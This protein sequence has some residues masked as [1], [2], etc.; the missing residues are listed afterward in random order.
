MPSA[1]HDS[2][3]NT[4]KGNGADGSP[5]PSHL[6]RARSPIGQAGF[7]ADDWARQAQQH[8]GRD[9]HQQQRN[10]H[11]PTINMKLCPQCVSQGN[12]TYDYACFNCHHQFF[13]PKQRGT[14]GQYGSPGS[15]GS[16]GWLP[17][18]QPQSAPSQDAHPARHRSGS[19]GR[20]SPNPFAQQHS[21]FTHL[22]GPPSNATSQTKVCSCGKPSPINAQWCSGCGLKFSLGQGIPAAA[23]SAP[24]AV[25][26]SQHPTKVGINIQQPVMSYTISSGIYSEQV[27]LVQ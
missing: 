17:K 16:P 11:S 10:G 6:S 23:T 22:Q 8:V 13:E 21:M 19:D 5:L 3:D 27:P 4:L 15:L 9:Q 18:Q 1:C 24:Q 2:P 12:K 25:P 26:P 14:S 20:H 7:G